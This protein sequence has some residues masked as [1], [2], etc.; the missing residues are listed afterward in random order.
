MTGLGPALA[1]WLTSRRWYAGKDGRLDAV[2]VVWS[3]E[4]ADERA[5]DGPRCLLL[6]IAA[7]LAGRPAQYYQVPLGVRR[8]MPRWLTAQVV[9]TVD[10]DT[11]YEATADPEL[12][13]V[14]LRRIA[15]QDR[16][17]D[18]RFVAEQQGA[19]ELAARAGLAARVH[20]AEQS[21]TSVVYGDRYILKLFRV[22]VVGTNPDLEVH[23]RLSAEAAAP[24]APLLGSI[25]ARTPLGPV[26]VG[27]LQSYAPDA[28]D[29]WQL[30][31]R[32]GAPPL[33][34]GP[35]RSTGP[36]VPGPSG[37]SAP[38]AADLSALGAAVRAAHQ[39]LARSFGRA[40]MTAG[41][42]VR[43]RAALLARL[44]DALG[45]VPALLAH[46]Q[47][48]RAAF[49]RLVKLPAGETVQRVHGD[50]HLGQVLYA[51]GSWL[52]IDFEG[53]PG[54]PI[55]D[56]VTW[57]SPLQDV[58]GMLRSIDYAARFRSPRQAPGAESP[59]SWAARAKDSFC[60]GYGG[61]TPARAGL[62][63]AFELDKAVYEVVYEARNRPDWVHVPLRA[64]E[65]LTA[66]LPHPYTLQDTSSR[67][68]SPTR[69]HTPSHPPREVSG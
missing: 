4:I 6:I 5:H 25:E 33:V 29:G 61:I 20:R 13:A 43:T 46:E 42:L 32:A 57:R 2:E 48:L 60:R 39:S 22:V 54:A 41:G 63:R 68:P 17:A 56:R 14:L 65:E 49:S 37:R 9:T 30:A 19:L 40:A 67:A 51:A 38:D 21:N 7:H 44:D 12:M 66:P 18:V 23:R 35:E 62:L 34:L 64:V 3:A 52:L 1:Q 10:G 16:P 31:T 11:Y 26:T 69:P 50:L 55:R 24:V 53:E 36:A 27:L 59:G 47:A 58:A 8:S 45:R 15:D 28:V